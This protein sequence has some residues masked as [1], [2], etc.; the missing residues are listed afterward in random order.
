MLR[1]R[2][3]LCTFMSIEPFD[4]DFEFDRAQRHIQ[5]GEFNAALEIA[6]RMKRNGYREAAQQIKGDVDMTSAGDES[7]DEDDL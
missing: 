7:E 3:P 1:G 2:I 6:E 4:I 5:D